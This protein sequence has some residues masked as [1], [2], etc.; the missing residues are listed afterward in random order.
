MVKTMSYI[1][2]VHL[3]KLFPKT[4]ADAIHIEGEWLVVP[5]VN[6]L[7]PLTNNN[8]PK[9]ADELIKSFEIIGD[10][11]VALAGKNNPTAPVKAV[12][13]GQTF[14]KENFASVKDKIVSQGDKV[15]FYVKNP[16]W[17]K[18]QTHKLTISIIQDRP[19]KFTIERTIE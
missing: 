3:N 9:N 4:G 11:T 8:P 19:I 14:T 5:F 7:N 10:D 1:A 15:L 2:K 18:G 12:W 16:G 17:A 13:N 6:V